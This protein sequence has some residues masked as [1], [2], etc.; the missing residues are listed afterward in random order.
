MVTMTTM[1]I[2]TLCWLPIQ[3]FVIIDLFGF[4]EFSTFY[5]K[6]EMMG[7]C[8]AFLGASVNAFIFKFMSREFRLAFG[9]ASSKLA[10][11]DF[12][13]PY[14]NLSRY[15]GK[16]SGSEMNETFMSILSDSSNNFEYS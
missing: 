10:C 1:L 16:E 11:K 4:T 12:D 3:V 9:Y 2:R 5:R 7:V 14:P 13:E 8:C 6:A 15:K